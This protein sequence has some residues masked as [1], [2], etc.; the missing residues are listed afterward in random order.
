MTPIVGKTYIALPYAFVVECIPSTIPQCDP[1]V[2]MAGR[3]IDPGQLKTLFETGDE[4]QTLLPQA[5]SPL[6]G[7]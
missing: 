3:V 6:E 7:L 4:L 1:S 2:L 5:F